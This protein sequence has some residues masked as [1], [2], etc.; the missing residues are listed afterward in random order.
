V[1]IRRDYGQFFG[2]S[3]WI[4]LG[5]AYLQLEY[6]GIYVVLWL[7]SVVFMPFWDVTDRSEARLK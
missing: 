1:S 5:A 7:T 6:R 2:A 4:F 3:V